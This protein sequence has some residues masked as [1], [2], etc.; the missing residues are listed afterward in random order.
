MNVIRIT[1][2]L[3][4]SERRDMLSGLL[5]IKN[6]ST[7]FCRLSGEDGVNVKLKSA[8]SDYY[9]GVQTFVVG[10]VVIIPGTLICGAG[11]GNA[12]SVLAFFML[13]SLF[14]WSCPFTSSKSSQIFCLFNR[15]VKVH[16]SQ[17]CHGNS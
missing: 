9:K 14:Q 11:L 16:G 13:R 8:K 7:K 17:V 10:A 5:Q 4:S 15:Q 1:L 6:H 3:K 12:D 2:L